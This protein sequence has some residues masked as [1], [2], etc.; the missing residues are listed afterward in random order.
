VT[1]L[2][3]EIEPYDRGMLDVGEGNLV[4]WDAC[5]NPSGRPA[6]VIHAAWLPRAKDVED[7]ATVR[8]N[9]NTLRKLPG[10]K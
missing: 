9:K 3:P 8:A 2:Y 6:V 7:L 1:E 5:G 4:Y 10:Q